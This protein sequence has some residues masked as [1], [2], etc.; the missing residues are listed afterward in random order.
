M[1]ERIKQCFSPDH[2]QL[3]FPNPERSKLGLAESRHVAPFTRASRAASS[4]DSQKVTFTC[5]DALV[6]SMSLSSRLLPSARARRMSSALTRVPLIE[7]EHV[8]DSSA[9]LVSNVETKRSSPSVN[10]FFFLRLET[11]SPPRLDSGDFLRREPNRKSRIEFL[12]R[13]R[14]TPIIENF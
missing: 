7:N 14:E 13:V 2:R 12:E 4:I 1:F 8:H 3:T 10:L 11:S 5:G 9:S 6:V